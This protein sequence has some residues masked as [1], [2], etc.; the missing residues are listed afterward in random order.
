MKSLW[1]L[2]FVVSLSSAQ[3]KKKRKRSDEDCDFSKK[4]VSVGDQCSISWKKLKPI[5]H[6]TQ[7]NLG[8]AWVQYKV[9]KKMGSKHDAQKEMDS[10]IVPVVLG[11]R[12]EVY[13]LDHHH[14]MAALDFSGYDKTEVTLSVTCD[15]RNASSLADFW[16]EM[17]EQ[18]L[19]Y[20][21]ARPSGRPNA[22]PDT[23]L[24]WTQMPSTFTHNKA[25]GSS[26]ANDNWRSLVGYS[27]K[28]TAASC[29]GADKYCARAMIK[30]CRKQN[31]HGIPYFEFRWGYFFNA[32]FLDPTRHWPSQA[33]FARF[34]ARYQA[35]PTPSAPTPVATEGWEQAAAL[36]V[37]L[38]RA[39]ATSSYSVPPSQTGAA[40]PLPGYAGPGAIPTADPACALPSCGDFPPSS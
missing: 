40:G 34:R 10:K 21:F 1:I 39:N 38:A 31:N 5:L 12:N 6:P 11:Y 16:T 18:Q 2:L 17:L 24:A 19:A 26:F 3:G 27:R 25:E 15:Y 4:S 23:K 22:L 8:Y 35:L 28:V 29:P 14:V 32:A 36:L 9:E 20:P 30:P 33:E 37:P 13:P 7:P